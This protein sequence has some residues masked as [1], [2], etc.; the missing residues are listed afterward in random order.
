MTKPASHAFRLKMAKQKAEAFLRDEG[1]HGTPGR[2]H[3]HS[4]G[5]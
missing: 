5:P 2:S 4:S 3:R 1:I